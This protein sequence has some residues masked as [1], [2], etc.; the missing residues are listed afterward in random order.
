M[1]QTI[2]QNTNLQREC[3]TL[4]VDDCASILGIGR[5][6]A[7]SLVREAETTEGT[8]FKVMR[9]GTSLLISKKS[10]DAYL[11]ANGL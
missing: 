8:P 9:V 5:S 2:K 3:R 11:D 10:F 6:A 1:N 4:R 7:Y